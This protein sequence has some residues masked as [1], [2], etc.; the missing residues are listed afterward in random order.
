MS[1]PKPVDYYLGYSAHQ[2]VDF[3]EM[4][5][6]QYPE[7]RTHHV[8]DFVVNRRTC[9][10]IDL[11]PLC[12]FYLRLPY[13]NEFYFEALLMID[14]AQVLCCLDVNRISDKHET[15]EN[16]CHVLQLNFSLETLPLLC[17]HNQDLIVRLVL[18]GQPR[19]NE[20]FGLVVHGF[21]I[22][23]ES[24]ARSLL[25]N[26]NTKNYIF[27]QGFTRKLSCYMGRMVAERPTKDDEP[28]VLEPPLPLY[29][30]KTCGVK[31]E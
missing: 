6:G 17:V 10:L 15:D 23:D 30:H 29:R 24:E 16:G 5:P 2:S 4:I 21:R 27:T 25:H 22:N 3:K 13:P 12:N 18:T 11:L 14:G 1:D 31:L 9:S 20:Y 26:R 19:P 8:Y 28:D 7:R